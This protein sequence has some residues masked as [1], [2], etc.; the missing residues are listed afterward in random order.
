MKKI[1]IVTITG[2]LNYGNTLQNLGLVLFLR[3][4]GYYV[5]T[6]LNEDNTDHQTHS[7]KKRLKEEIKI[8][9]NYKG[10]RKE[11]IFERKRQ[12]KYMAFD[13]RY[14]PFSKIHI[15][16]NEITSDIER[17]YDYFIAG[18]DIIWNPIYVS[19]VMLL[20]GIP[21]EKKIAYAASFGV[22]ELD[23][24]KENRYRQALKT[25]KSISTREKDGANIVKKIIGKDV[26]TCVDPTLLISAKK[27]ESIAQKP[28]W[29][30]IDNKNYIVTYFL[31]ETPAYVQKDIKKRF[32]ENIPVINFLNKNNIDWYSIDP[33]EFLYLIQHAKLVYTDSFHGSLF[34]V[35]FK[36]PFFAFSRNEMG[37]HA[38]NS[39]TSRI[40]NL[41]TMFSIQN[42]YITDSNL[43]PSVDWQDVDYTHNNEILSREI[44]RAE[45]YLKKALI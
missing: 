3:K 26:E 18:S 32:G 27:W 22:K 37:N 31:G 43:L 10:Q 20:E 34:S 44:V 33:A 42:R 24:E 13:K 1:G 5:E 17:E 36:R 2:G 9:L 40:E 4:L 14:I 29:F 21:N 39:L 45:E 35:I 6:I 16:R 25:F 8:L 19:D 15:N 30:H 23:S 11:I 28:D 41:V 12:E 38:F 7:L